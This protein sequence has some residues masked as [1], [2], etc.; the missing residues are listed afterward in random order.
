M[1][2]LVILFPHYPSRK[3]R[4]YYMA[5]YGLG[6]HDPQALGVRKCDLLAD[7][8]TISTYVCQYKAL[9]VRSCLTTS[10]KPLPVLVKW[11][12]L[13]MEGKGGGERGKGG[14]RKGRKERKREEKRGKAL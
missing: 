13:W 10:T 3:V 12:C 5:S 7:S 11:W 6:V 14:G 9:G 2:Y 4:P 1:L 8:D